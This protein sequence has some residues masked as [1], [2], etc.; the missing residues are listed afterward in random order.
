M[1]DLNILHERNYNTSLKW[2]NSNSAIPMWLADMD[3]K[4]PDVI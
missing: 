2:F 1:N 3:F 4:S